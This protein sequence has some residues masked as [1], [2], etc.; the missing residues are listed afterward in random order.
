M[1]RALLLALA[2]A[3]LS[4]AVLALSF[5]VSRYNVK[6]QRFDDSLA[7]FLFMMSAY[8]AL[9]LQDRPGTPDEGRIRA[10]LGRYRA[11]THWEVKNVAG[12]DIARFGPGA[13]PFLARSA[14]QADPF[15]LEGIARALEH[16]GGAQ[17][18]P[19]LLEVIRRHGLF[20]NLSPAR[21]ERQPLSLRHHVAQALGKTGTQEAADVL[22]DIHAQAKKA[23]AS[24]A[25]TVLASIA[26]TGHGAP[27]L[28]GAA[29]DAPS[30]RELDDFIWPLA[31]TRDARAIDF[32]AGLFARPELSLRRSARDA[33]DQAGGP[34][35][36][37]AVLHVLGGTNDEFLKSWL[38]QTNLD[39]RDARGNPDVVPAL[40]TYLTHPALAWEARYALLRIGTAEANAAIV[41]RFD[42]L[43]PDELIRD[44]EYASAHAL[45]LVERYLASPDPRVRRMMLDKLP[46]MFVPG[47]ETLVARALSDGDPWVRRAAR[48]A[49]LYMDRVLFWKGLTDL[50]PESV[51]PSLFHAMRPTFFGAPLDHMLPLLRGVHAA[52]VGLSALLA[53]ALLFGTAKIVEPYRFDLF[54]A[55]LLLEGFA[56]DFLLLEFGNNPW[57]LILGATACHIALLAGVLCQPREHLPGELA[58][59][60]ERLMGASVWLAMPLLFAFTTPAL[61]Q[62]LRFAFHDSAWSLALL[63]LFALVTVLVVEQWA[64]RW[65]LAPRSETTEARLAALLW[66]ALTGLLLFAIFAW[67]DQLWQSGRRDESLVTLL[68]ALPLIW[69]PLGRLHAFRSDDSV[70]AAREFPPLPGGRLVAADLGVRVA[71]QPRGRS[72]PVRLVKAA[73]VLATAVAAAIMAG[74]KG[75]ALS[76]LLAL[77]IAPIGAAVATLAIAWLVPAWVI[78]LRGGY[79]RVAASRAGLAFQDTGWRRRLALP[80]GL[81]RKLGADP[82]AS[83]PERRRALQPDEVDWI[84]AVSAAQRGAAA[85]R[86]AA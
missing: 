53:L 78:H 74:I 21:L 45:P 52:G 3:V 42:R 33:L 15:V 22:I 6:G 67:A 49:A 9:S 8:K 31:R 81:Q 58:G 54:T 11:T 79:A 64:L 14:V 13:I 16:I 34:A 48:E 72:W 71:L 60:F 28:L 69:L 59:R 44:M 26:D 4:A 29:R 56:G 10:A 50:L 73:I 30:A 37:P 82:D 86:G 1:R 12:R 40:E 46:E 27:F 61:A 43:Q 23:N 57:R 84:A 66:F 75:K 17:T 20:D 7:D 36:I 85:A 70:D 76:M 25:P 38:I 68:A 65:S 63:A 5:S 51:G 62:A 77:F 19:L 18:L 39:D 32:L 2:V 80:L 35:A 83:D 41:R 47:T 24:W 55:F